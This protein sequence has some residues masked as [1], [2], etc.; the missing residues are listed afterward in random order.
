MDD[1][2]A[3]CGVTKMIVYR[4]FETKEELYRAVL[5]GVFAR[6]ADELRSGLQTGGSG[7]TA[8]FGVRMQLTVAREDPNGY[9]LLWRHAAREPMF[10]EYAADARSTA[11]AVVR[12]MLHL[13][14]G[15]DML[16]QWTAEVTF[17]WLVDATLAWLDHGSPDRD[18]EYLE[19]TTAAFRAVREAW[20][21]APSRG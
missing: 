7:G 8:G 12:R 15:D 16:D 21:S 20:A 2:A 3:A 9:T 6:L 14:S 19:R 13:E 10:A 5:E 18:S 17:T 4:H 11:V 1:V